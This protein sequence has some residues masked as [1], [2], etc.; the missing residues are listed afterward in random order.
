MPV[1]IR[2]APVGE[3]IGG[4][5]GMAATLSVPTPVVDPACSTGLQLLTATEIAA[6]KSTLKMDVESDPVRVQ[7]MLDLFYAF[8]V[9]LIAVWAIKRLL[10]LFS[11]EGD[12]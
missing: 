9:V 5:G 10:D 12:K 3:N 1:C 7:D 4:G 11:G 8:L 6:N 2:I